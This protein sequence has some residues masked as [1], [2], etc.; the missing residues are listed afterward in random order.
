MTCT[1]KIT[2]DTLTD[3]EAER[4][5]S[6]LRQ[7]PW[8]APDMP[9][10]TDREAERYR[11]YLKSTPL[12]AHFPLCWLADLQPGIEAQSAPSGISMYSIDYYAS[13]MPFLRHLAQLFPTLRAK[14]EGHYDR[15]PVNLAKGYD[16]F[17]GIFTI[18]L[19]D[20]AFWEEDIPIV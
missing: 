4:L 7:K 12:N 16:D 19:C 18:S 15:D 14:A 6:Y 20:G 10:L 11:D 17:G 9:W 3:H 1:V 8:E 13:V 2:W 5:L